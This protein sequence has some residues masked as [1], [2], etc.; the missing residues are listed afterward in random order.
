MALEL[1]INYDIDEHLNRN[2]V[3]NVYMDRMYRSNAKRYSVP[4]ILLYTMNESKKGYHWFVLN[5]V[6][7]GNNCLKQIRR[8]YK[9]RFSWS[10]N[11]KSLVVYG[12]KIT[13]EVNN[14]K[15][16]NGLI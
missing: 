2:K 1:K 16:L 12:L 14:I 10:V 15:S 5:D 8:R 4:G 13:G 7:E 3:Y 11:E 6:V 9:K